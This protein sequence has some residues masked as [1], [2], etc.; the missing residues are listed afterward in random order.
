[1]TE[2]L[3][4]VSIHSSLDPLI[5]RHRLAL[6]SSGDLLVLG[7]KRAEGGFGYVSPTLSLNGSSPRV[8]LLVK[9]F[10]RECGSD[11]VDVATVISNLHSALRVTNP[12]SWVDELLAVP[13]IIATVSIGREERL[14]AVMLDLEAFGFKSDVLSDGMS[15]HAATTVG[16]RIDLAFR[17]AELAVL[18]EK[19][20][21]IHGDHNPANVLINR[22]TVDLQLIDFDAGVVALTGVERPLTAGHSDAY[23]P[24]EVKP[25]G[26]ED[27]HINKYV[28]SAERWSIGMMI[29]K[30]LL[31]ACHPAFFLREISTAAIQ[32][33][34]AGVRRWP[35]IDTSSG[36]FRQG[37]AEAYAALLEEVQGLPEA[38]VEL[39]ADLF[40][41]GLD[42]E[43]RPSAGD[44]LAAIR[45]VRSPP[46][47]LDLSV[48]PNYVLEGTE[49]TV[50]WSTSQAETVECD[51]FGVLP[52]FGQASFVAGEFTQL[53]FSARNRWGTTPAF[54]PVQVLPLPRIETV[55][56]PDFPGFAMRTEIPA[57]PWPFAEPRPIR[58]DRDQ[59][60]VC[61]IVSDKFAGL[62]ARARDLRKVRVRAPESAVADA[63]GPVAPPIDQFFLLPTSD[64][65]KVAPQLPPIPDFFSMSLDPWSPYDSSPLDRDG[66]AT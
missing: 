18:L 39:L 36:L 2:Q 38:L 57:P 32:E 23:M 51:A 61:H 53:T 62:H 5:E 33:Y 16:E 19:I 42:G 59:R 28:Q 29:G 24:P 17:Y 35:A 49:A 7:D 55:L 31:G 22:T 4:V 58:S 8:A 9:V 41:A 6:F 65:G 46:E 10:K 48:M 50:R 43:Q 60:S 12:S 20:H 13:L 26:T 44:W 11:A 27:P 25:A 64:I 14:A 15:Y 56:A 40:A 3:T 34:A 66:L 52:P 54:T 45:T 21:F 47:F 30:I 37:S 63:R 1:V